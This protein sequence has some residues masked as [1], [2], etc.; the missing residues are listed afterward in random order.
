MY[1]RQKFLEILDRNDIHGNK[2]L[3]RRLNGR[4]AA[5]GREVSLKR[6]DGDQGVSTI[7]SAQVSLYSM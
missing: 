1:D 6:K 5:I 4:W 3:Q 7:N 2:N